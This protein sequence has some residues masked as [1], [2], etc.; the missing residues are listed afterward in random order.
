MAVQLE[1]GAIQVRIVSESRAEEMGTSV[2]KSPN[3][4]RGFAK[5]GL[6][7]TELRPSTVLA[8][9]LLP[10]VCISA[11]AAGLWI[12]LNVVAFAVLALLAGYAL[13]GS[14]LSSNA[15]ARAIL[16]APSA[17][18]LTLSALT[19]FWLRL[20]LPLTS[21]SVIWLV[22]AAVGGAVL[23]RDRSELK[24]AKVEYGIPLVAL[25]AL[26][27][28]IYFIPS[29]F[30]D[31][32]MRS[33]G[34]FSWFSIDTQYYHS[35]VASIRT[36]VGQPK[37]PGTFTADLHYHFGPYAVAAAISALSGISTGDAM[38]RV[39]RGVEQWAL[40]FSSLGLGTLLSLRATS[41]T[42]GGFLSVAG[43]FFYGSVLS[44]F[45]GVVNPRPVAPW[46]ILFESGG[47]FPTNGGPFSHILLGASVLHGL[48]ALTSILALCLA[49]REAKSAHPWRVLT[50]LTLPALM[51]EVNLPAAGYSLGVVAI[52]LFWGHL[53]NLRSWL[54]MGAM[55]GLFLGAYWLMGYS[56]APHMA[57]GEIQLSRLPVYWWT[58]VMWFAVA[59]GVRV[60]SFG[61][62]TQRAKDPLAVL[63]LVSFLGLLAF[64]WV[65]AFWMENGKYG[66][67]YLQ[68]IFS[69]FAF[70]RIPGRFWQRDE[71]RKWIKEW[72][73]IEEKGLIIFLIAGVLI[74]IF[75]YLIHRAAGINHFRARPLVCILFLAVLAILSKILKRNLS[76][77]PIVSAIITA[78]LLV[79]FLGWIPPW[80]KYRTG[81]QRYNVTLTPG[82]VRGLQRL[83]EIASRSERFATNKHMPTGGTGE[84]TADSYAYGTLSGRPVLLEGSYDGA[85]ENL[86]DFAALSHDNDLLF[87]TT[88]PSVLR[89]VAQ[90][91]SV[92]WLVLRAGT[93]LDLPRPLPPWLVEQQDCGD[94][95]IY[96]ID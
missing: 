45:S 96:R 22:L 59:L 47:Q 13:V 51:V 73:S 33:D 10:W 80:L 57:H 92:R 52:L 46:P 86:P 12:G 83:H 41:K 25:S 91:Y 93:D 76:I 65:G 60:I 50:A 30:N 1:V 70:S 4:S 75:G 44:L 37:M 23:W 20:S 62:V 64:S 24:T 26:I 89:N 94:L 19:A 29:A 55:L 66:V 85:E 72:L 31:A 87:T 5:N 71:R 7:G 58:F 8:L 82:E 16:L 77:S 34:S 2:A 53:T 78:V 14:V 79:G 18:I 39:T 84:G 63:V 32:V 88:D 95:K 61:W 67:Y 49:Q 36:S 9:A 28:A 81:G 27:C 21:L 68:A 38:V 17:G 3:S 90:S 35:M 56:H 6:L 48:V 69:I 74:G 15:R 54:Y 11:L 40:I 42:F 43:L